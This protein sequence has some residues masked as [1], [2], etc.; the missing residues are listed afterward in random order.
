MDPA[1]ILDSLNKQQVAILLFID[2]S[3]EFDMVKHGIL[4]DKLQHYRIRGTALKWFKSSMLTADFNFYNI[5]NRF[6]N[7][8]NEIRIL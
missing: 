5:W 4:L 2:F 8:A 7:K 1:P 3:K 6:G